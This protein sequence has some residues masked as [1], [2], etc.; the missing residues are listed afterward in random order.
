MESESG[1]RR[2]AAYA[3]CVRDDGAV[4]LARMAPGSPDAGSWTLPGG[5]VEFG[6]H[7]DDAVLRELREETGLSGER[8]RVVAVYSHTY[9]R[10][11]TRP[12]PPFQHVGLIYEVRI[13]EGELLHEIGG[14]T[15][16]CQWV[17]RSGLPSHPLVP[18]AA[19]AV[20]QLIRAST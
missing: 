3:F 4:L 6:E 5:G 18:L 8:G 13:Q 20:A 7:P 14:S 11:P 10:S 1:E 15:D 2:L 9:R 16:L 12:R 19:F 17:A